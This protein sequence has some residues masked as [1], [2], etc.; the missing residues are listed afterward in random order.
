MS[1]TQKFTNARLN[2]IQALYASELNDTPLEKIVFQFLNGEI[3]NR[4]ID[5]DEQGH[6]TFLPLNETDTELFTKIVRE[7]QKHKT[8]I[9]NTILATLSAGWDKERIELLLQSILRAGIGEFFAQPDLDAPIII[10]EYT[11]ITR[12]FYDGP[13]V[14]LVNAILDKFSKVIRS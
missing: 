2:A 4:I 7:V 8:D 1:K 6:E 12:S 3:G 9:D 11:D 13:E 10:N 5:E 14:R